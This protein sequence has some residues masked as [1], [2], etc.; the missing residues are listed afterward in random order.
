[1]VDGA[2][3]NGYSNWFGNQPDNYNGDN[4]GVF[5][6][7]Y[8]MASANTP[9]G[10]VLDGWTVS[11]GPYSPGPNPFLS[12][13]FVVEYP[14]PL[15]AITK[16]SSGVSNGI[17]YE[18]Y[19]S[20]FMLTWSN[21]LTYAKDVL[22]GGL[23]KI[24]DAATNAFVS[25][26]IGDPSLWSDSGSPACNYIGPYIG[27]YQVAGSAEPDSGWYWDDGT[28]LEGYMNCFSNQPD[29]YNGDN[30]GVF[31]NAFE[32]AV[33]NSKWGDVFSLRTISEGPYSPGPNPFLSNSFVFEQVLAPR[34]KSNVLERAPGPLPVFGVLA[35]FR[36][37]RR[38]RRRGSVSARW[39]TRTEGKVSID[40]GSQR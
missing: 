39:G 1:M 23:V 5:Y 11:V 37:S 31:Y 32:Q 36:W 18:A 14:F 25:S 24:K 33:P 29:N 13:S 35:A 15:S 38:L 19:R 10:D 17:L 28:P 3:I 22:G 12:N 9:W 34:L 21:A 4:V 16:V 7:A 20:D 40:S 6:N 30:V 8:E 27:L 26:L 2:A